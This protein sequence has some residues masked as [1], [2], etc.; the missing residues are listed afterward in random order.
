M[1][2]RAR[3]IISASTGN[4]G[5]SVAFASQRA[6]VPCTVAVPRGNNPQKNAAMRAL[7]RHRG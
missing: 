3:G 1:S 5:Q 4:H 2:E 7:R 6:G